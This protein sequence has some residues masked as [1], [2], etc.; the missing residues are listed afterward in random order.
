M[1][2]TT[3]TVELDEA[4]VERIRT[5]LSNARANAR[6]DRTE[7]ATA[8]LTINR[9]FVSPGART[10]TDE[11]LERLIVVVRGATFRDNDPGLTSSFSLTRVALWDTLLDLQ[12][13]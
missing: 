8:R 3:A 11:Q 4:T 5:F 2:T 1:T 10:I 7:W 9:L 12:H 6:V 13:R